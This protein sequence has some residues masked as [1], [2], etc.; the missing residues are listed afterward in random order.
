MAE[1][2]IVS[3]DIFDTALRR[4]LV[5]PSD[6]FYAMESV[7]G[8]RE[9]ASLPNFARSR[10]S[11][12]AEAWRRTRSGQ[13][14]TLAD[15]YRVLEEKHGLKPEESV[16]LQDLELETERRFTYPDPRFLRLA[17]IAR[18][19]G[20]KVIFLSDMYLPSV[21]LRAILEAHGF[22]N[23]EVFA[24][25]DEGGNKA[26]GR[27]YRLVAN[28]LGHPAPDFLHF[29]DNYY[30]DYFRARLNGWRAIHVTGD[31]D[32]RSL[33][34]TDRNNATPD[35][36]R[37]F[38]SAGRGLVRARRAG[39]SIET[40]PDFWEE[41]GYSVAGPIYFHFLH[42]LCVQAM[43][44]GVSRLLLCSRDGF[45]LLGGF[46]ILRKV[47]G[48]R[49][50]TV[51][52][53][54]S[55]RLFNLAA[56][57]EIN[58]TSLEFLLMPTPGMK[59]RDFITR[60]G[61]DPAVHAPLLGRLGFASLDQQLVHAGFGRFIQPAYQQQL[62]S[63]VKA[64]QEELLD[65]AQKERRLVLEYF[66]EM[67]PGRSDTAVV[68]LGWK[69]TVCTSLC[70]LLRDTDPALHP[71]TYYFGT[72]PHARDL[73]D[74]G[75]QIKSFLFHL[76]VPIQRQRIVAG[77]EGIVEMLFHAPHGSPLNFRRGSRGIEP[78][79]G[80][81][82]YDEQAL[83]HLE[84]MRTAAYRYIQDMAELFPAF[85]NGTS[86]PDEVG[87][88]LTRLTRHP[89]LEEARNL[90]QIPYRVSYGDR[91]T[92]HCLAKLPTVSERGMQSDLAAYESAPWKEG[93]LAQV[94][95]LHRIILRT[96]HL[97][98]SVY[99]ALTSGTLLVS[100]RW[101]FFRR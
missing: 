94:S 51:Y 74:A 50:D 86:S 11:A 4:K 35:G 42:W 20:L 58:A 59:L 90:G 31:L 71:Q 72:S 95:I 75:G 88:I 47:W 52:F 56:I 38:V 63:W 101:A 32:D 93:Y 33:P 89:R 27:L 6:L 98:H 87:A 97:L 99:V 55:R 1:G 39:V 46:E 96:V 30:A 81:C 80:T 8:E 73:L 7:L 43:Q 26:S 23:P 13:Q 77:H 19:L 57:R 60:L 12:E 18:E 53:Y 28:K 69:A 65:Q 79:F 34:V 17:S 85:Q 5:S 45:P 41:F 78:I 61:L 70:R 54:A 16:R 9:R 22:P 15:I 66:A 49:L 68:D 48:V 3:F 67:A 25:G 64:S 84:I 92:V 37:I 36:Q 62:E 40:K 2:K 24:S 76:G 29:G 21:G 82:E 10:I 44:D 14:I 83:S 91:G 100:L